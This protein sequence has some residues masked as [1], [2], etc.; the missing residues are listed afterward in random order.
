MPNIISLIQIISKTL[1]NATQ[2]TAQFALLG[3]QHAYSQ[4]NL[5][6]DTARHCKF[7]M[8][9]GDWTGSYRQKH[10]SMG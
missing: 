6:N 5:H 9:T 10:A 1:S 3:L 7:N 2:E 4:L 8:V